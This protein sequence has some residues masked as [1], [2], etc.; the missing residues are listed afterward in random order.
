MNAAS[1]AQGQYSPANEPWYGGHH[2]QPTLD[3]AMQAISKARSTS[4]S[5]IGQGAVVED[6]ITAGY[7]PIAKRPGTTDNNPMQPTREEIEARLAATEA[8]VDARLS[9]FEKTMTEALGAVRGEVSGM[10]VDVANMRTDVVREISVAAQGLAE[11]RGEVGGVKTVTNWTLGMIGVAI[12][13]V[14]LWMAIRQADVP[15]PPQPPQPVIIQVPSS[16]PP[17]PPAATSTP[18][19]APPQP[20][21]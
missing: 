4:A 9:G 15:T 17:A 10:R 13:A 18:P 1:S 16:P 19:P 3:I 20:S 2:L 6:R 8:R 11:L 5:A 12:G 14:A 21:K 7:K